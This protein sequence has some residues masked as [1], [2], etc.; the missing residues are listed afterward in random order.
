MGLSS[1]GR[2]SSV[3]LCSDLELSG[4]RLEVTQELSVTF[5]P[6]HK[7]LRLTPLFPAHQRQRLDE[8]C[9]WDAGEENEEFGVKWG[10]E[11]MHLAG[12][13]FVLKGIKSES[14]WCTNTRP[15]RK[16]T[17]ICIVEVLPCAKCQP[18][19]LEIYIYSNSAFTF[20]LQSRYYPHSTDEETDSERLSNRWWIG[21]LRFKPRFIL[22]LPGLSS[23]GT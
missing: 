15:G 10:Q 4:P 13:F 14:P 5:L 8:H 12:G 20:S 16:I 17:G 9:F 18:L 21:E 22:T 23:K 6:P 1:G 7:L 3:W 2:D 19:N 11:S